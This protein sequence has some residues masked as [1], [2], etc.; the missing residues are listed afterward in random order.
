MYGVTKLAGEN[1]CLDANPNAIIIRT[2]LWFIQF[3]KV[4][5]K[6]QCLA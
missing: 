3:W 4:I 5:L 2:S 6:K 1:A